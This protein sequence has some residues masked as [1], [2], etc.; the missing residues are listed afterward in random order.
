MGQYY[1]YACYVDN[2]VRYVGKGKGVRLEHCKS[3][4]SSCVELN[5]DL[6]LGK[7]IEVIK[8]F[9]G[10]SEY[11]ALVRENIILNEIDNPNLYNKYKGSSGKQGRFIQS[12]IFDYLLT[13]KNNDKLTVTSIRKILKALYS[14]HMT[15]AKNKGLKTI[16]YDCISTD[17]ISK[18]A[19]ELGYRVNSRKRL[20]LAD[21]K[22]VYEVC[23]LIIDK[24]K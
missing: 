14:S 9:E 3:G 5:R 21:E 24:I 13:I 2:E 18:L 16:R 15:I 1:V 8:V 7:E 23:K 19:K 17:N 20:E 12:F 4:K 11:E 6:F 10:L 22:D